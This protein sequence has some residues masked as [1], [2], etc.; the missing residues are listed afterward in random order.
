MIAKL[1]PRKSRRKA[2]DLRIAQ[3]RAKS[4]SL[5]KIARSEGVAKG[6]V[7]LALERVRSQPEL[8]EA[9]KIIDYDLTT[10]ARKMKALTEKKKLQEIKYT[11]NKGNLVH[12]IMEVDDNGTQLSASK[13]MM[14]VH[15]GGVGSGSADARKASSDNASQVVIN[16]GF[17][18]PE[19]AREVIEAI[20]EG[21]TKE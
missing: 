14:E 21:K 20:G 7:F 1:Q 12:R 9:F 2:N 11:N 8:L 6:T 15:L 10:A 5:N 16:L 13:F 3:K 19:R 4:M 18:K 17:L